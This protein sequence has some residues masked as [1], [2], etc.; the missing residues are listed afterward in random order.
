[1]KAVDAEEDQRAGKTNILTSLKKGERLSE[2]IKQG[3]LS[4]R[5][6]GRH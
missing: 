5:P 4:Q 1:M 2:T 3:S 6:L